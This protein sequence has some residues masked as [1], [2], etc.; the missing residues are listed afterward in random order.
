MQSQRLFQLAIATAL[1]TSAI[2]VAPPA[3]AASFF[4]D[5]NPSNEEGKA[6]IQLADRGIISGYM[7]GTFKPAN[8][9]TR[10]QAAKILAGILKLDTVHVKNPQFKDIKPGDENYGAIAALANAGIIN[11]ANGY[12]Y[13]T[14]N[15]TRE[16]M[17][18]MIAKGFGL[19]SPSNTQLPFTDVKKGNEFEPH[20]KA[21]FANGI[22]KG[23]SATTFGPKSNVKRSQLAA[24]VV[25]AEKMLG[26]A[27]IYAKQF[28]Q[29]Y[30]F[31]F[32]GGLEPATDIFAWDENEDMTESI[33]ITPLKEGTGKLVITGFTDDSEDFTEIFYLVH[34][35]NVNGKLK[36]TLEEVKEEDY[37]ENLSF[38]I[39]ESHLPFVPTELT[40][41]NTNGQALA[42]NLYSFNQQDQTL[43]ILQNGQ[44][45]VTFSDGTQQQK[46]AAEVYSYD[47]VRNID[48]YHLTDELILTTQ[49][50]PFEPAYVALESFGFEPVPV[51][52]TILNGQLHVTPKAEGLAILHLT[53][54]NE[55]TAYL[56]IESK[57]IAGQW[58]FLVSEDEE[59]F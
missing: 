15:I 14:Q 55:E 19:T 38:D 42:P 39:T 22:T 45:I 35:K 36:T 37:I 58:A 12:F 18:K 43:S 7:D 29:D 33:T 28:K 23:T 16:Q 27:T 6:I 56:Y 17:S 25:R 57:K 3:H 9:I 24:F 53:G 52:A 32:Y 30:I 2:I 8:P 44:F 1:A 48:L 26:N 20:I 4:P 47:F 10:T 49:E 21:L 50:L 11:G 46:M 31:A 5:I 41:H 40:V 54:K 34:V 13:P 59:E 51:K